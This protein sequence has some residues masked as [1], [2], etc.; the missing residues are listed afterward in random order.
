[1]KHLQKHKDN[2]ILIPNASRAFCL[3]ASACL[4]NEGWRAEPLPMGGLEAIAEG[5]KYVHNDMCLPAQIVI[6]EA[7]LALKSGKYDLNKVTVGTAKVLCDCRL[8]NYMPLARKAL[9][10]AGFAQVPL[11]TTDQSDTKNA[12]P[13]FNFSSLTYSKIVWGVVQTDTIE[14]LRRKIRPYEIEKGETDRVVE[15][16]F[17]EI[18]EGLAKG[19]IP[20][21]M[22]P[23]KKAIKDI[24][25]IRYDRSILREPV[26]V[27]GEYLLTFHPGSNQ[28]IERYLENN[29]MEVIFPRMAGIYRHLFLQHT[30]AEMK[31]FKVKHKLYDKY[32]ALVGNWFMDLAVNSADKI[33]SQ[34]PLFERDLTLQEK[35]KYSDD[36]MHHSIL[37]GESFIITADILHYAERGV[38]AFVILQPFGCLPNHI[39][40]RGVI[41][42]IKETHPDIQILPLDYDPDVSFANIENRIQM[43]I[44]NA[45]EKSRM[46]K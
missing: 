36:I 40:G 21:S 14:Y 7:I 2:V 19:G 3:V 34:H 46:A 13:G 38:R 15:N 33:A 26:V 35:A 43:L 44:M 29:G 42:R 12:H 45:R 17:L 41:K 22:K 37:S 20:G 27:Q 18:A 10:E 11:M 4:R 30:I 39:C 31:E 24:C 8:S 23:F 6:G 5:K 16:A 9:D 28:N 32:Y 1:M 25:A